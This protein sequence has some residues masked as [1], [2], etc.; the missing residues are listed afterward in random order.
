VHIEC[1]AS[2]TTLHVVEVR[3]VCKLHGDGVTLSYG[4]VCTFCTL[5][6]RIIGQGLTP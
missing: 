3:I 2:S 5:S 6:H 4:S 1:N